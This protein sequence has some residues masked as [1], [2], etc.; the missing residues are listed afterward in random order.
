MAQV[1]ILGAGG[2]ARLGGMS[3]ADARTVGFLMNTRGLTELVIL[4]AG[5]AMGVLDERI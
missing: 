3:W 1:A 4:N 5:M 2:A